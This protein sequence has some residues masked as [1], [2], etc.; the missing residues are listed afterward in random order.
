MV[1]VVGISGYGITPDGKVWSYKRNKFLS[2]TSDRSGY[3]YVGLMD[4]GVRKYKKIHRLVAEAF[5]P[6]PENKPTVNH[7]NEIKYDNRV[8]NL[9]WMTYAENV[10]YSQSKKIGQ[11]TK[12]GVLVRT[13]KS[14]S[15]AKDVGG[16]CRENISN[17]CLGKPKHK[18]HRGFIWKFI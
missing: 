17:C 10:R 3:L 12:D 18:T 5:I 13:W 6:N 7:K 14:S 2:P 4:N 15:E 16:F 8:E 1:D 11:Y 9:E